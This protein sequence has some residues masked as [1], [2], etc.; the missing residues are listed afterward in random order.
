M[1]GGLVGGGFGGVG[2]AAE[3]VDYVEQ[4]KGLWRRWIWRRRA[5]VRKGTQPCT[6]QR[7]PIY[8]AAV[9]C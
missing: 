5:R 4:A 1:P 3:A 6:F 9:G 2:L 7:K 8:V